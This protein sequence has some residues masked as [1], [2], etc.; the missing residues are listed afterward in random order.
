MYT[1]NA[2]NKLRHGK[3]TVYTVENTINLHGVDVNAVIHFK[4]RPS[5]PDESIAKSIEVSKVYVLF[6]GEHQE[7]PWW[8]ILMMSD[9]LTSVILESKEWK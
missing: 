8:Q 6:D 3:M 2:P 7:V 4:Q 5:Y 9:Y 1:V